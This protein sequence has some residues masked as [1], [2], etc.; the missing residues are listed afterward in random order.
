VLDVLDVAAAVLL[1]AAFAVAAANAVLAPRLHRTGRA[2]RAV[3][4]SVLVPAR[5]EAENLRRNLPALLGQD[6]GGCEVLVLDDG[7][8]DGTAEAVRA[9]A[10]GARGRLRLL[11][12]APLPPGWTG[13]NWACHQL[14]RAAAGDVL[15][16]CDADVHA[17]PHAV[18]ATVALLE[19]HGAGAMTALPRQRTGGWAEAAVVP[20]VAQ[21]PVLALLPL[22]LVPRVR[23]PSV[24]MGNGQWLAFTREAYAAS[25]GHHAVRGDVLDDVRLARRAKA[26][27]V[28]L[29][30]ALAPRTLEVRMYRGWRQVRDGFRK[31]L[32]PLLGGGTTSCS[33]AVA[34]F[35]L[36]AVY[37]WLAAGRG[38]P[39][40]L[41][42]LA[43]L[44]ALRA[45]AAAALGHG[46]RSV[47]L[48]PAG[49]V[50]AL[51]I[52]MASWVGSR[53]G[54]VAWKG[55]VLPAAGAPAD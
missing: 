20:L 31:N 13:K 53:R 50:L 34:L 22:W 21:V 45:V 17:A 7:S 9:L 29:V 38:T 30:V 28:R 23:A 46:W 3:R 41:A 36:A 48:H 4:V 55:R 35:S 27:G 2:A 19:R 24:G 10:A 51:S 5:D 37:P 14:S 15:L 42:A 8:T 40:A 52:A 44:V 25:G 47:A 6:H 49:A 54:A 43:L 16:F 12:G 39:A 1:A 18:A 11:A 32:Y 26:A 33:V